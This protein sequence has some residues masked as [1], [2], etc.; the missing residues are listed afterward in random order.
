MTETVLQWF[1]L[2]ELV[3]LQESDCDFF[4]ILVVVALSLKSETLGILSLLLFLALFLF[5][6]FLQDRRLKL[7]LFLQLFDGL[8]LS[9]IFLNLGNTL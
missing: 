8:I 1:G 9:N 2:T 4:L 5:L 7:G 6:F 3:E